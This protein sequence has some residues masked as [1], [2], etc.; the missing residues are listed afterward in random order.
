MRKLF[1]SMSDYLVTLVAPRGEAFAVDCSY[2]PCANEDCYCSGVRYYMK[3]C[4]R[5]QTGMRCCD[6]CRYVGNYC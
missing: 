1:E 3:M 6:P 4:C 5:T 2:G